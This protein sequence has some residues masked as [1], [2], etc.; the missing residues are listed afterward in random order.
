PIFNADSS[1]REWVGVHTDITEQKIAA[2]KIRESESYFRRLTDTVP[3]II[4]ITEPD[5]SCSYLNKLWYDFTGQTK[6]QALGFGWLEAIHPKDREQAGEIF[7]SANSSQ[8]PFS[9]LSRFR[10]SGG[11]YRWAVDFGSPKFDANGVFEGMIGT[12]MDAHEEKLAEEKLAYRTALLEAHNQAGVDGIMLVDAKGKIISYNQR[13]IEIWNMPQ[14]I[15]AD[16]DD[17]AALTFA[18][19]QLLHPQ[20][21]IDK[22]RYLYENPTETSHDHLEFM[23]GKWVERNGY[24]VIGE[25][26]TNYAWSWT[27]R[28]ITKQKLFEK[29]IRDSEERFRLLAQTLPQLIWVTDELGNAEFSSIRW[30]EYSGLEPSGEAE[31]KAI[32]HPEDYNLINSAWIHSLTTGNIFKSEVRLKNKEDEYRWHSVNGEP[33]FDKGNK[34]IKW[35]G[36]FTD[37]NEQKLNDER[38]DEFVSIASHEMKT[39]LTTAK[40]YLQMLEF[41]LDESNGEAILF[42][43]KAI[44]SVDRLTE[45]A[46]ELLDVSKIRLGKLQYNLATFNFNDLIHDTVE[47]IQLTTPI[48]RIIKSGEVRDPVFGDKHRLQQVVINLLTNAIKYSPDADVVFIDFKQEGDTIQ[49]SVKDAGIGIAQSSLDKIF[50]KYHRIEDH[51]VHF[52]GLGIGL[53]ISFEII[54]R[55]KGK[56]WATSE[57]GKGSTF[58]FLLPIN[59]SSSQ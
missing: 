26:G 21:F 57:A 19:S 37:I 42:T 45:L 12:V 30:K 54:Q 7:I 43:K 9:N 8:K 16:Q 38:K 47:S 53:F 4:W 35:V 17:D 15:L 18:M 32:I 36:A 34:I 39:P 2:Q 3:A 40:A 6:E 31:W 23:D 44:E 5:G 28:D 25:D 55:H 24:P 1:L 11:E 20:L 41:T 52:Q 33:V 48:H 51:A 10:N 58:Y 29:E 14:H 27:F 49:V 59:N 50:D 22:V 56:L 13:F 46:S